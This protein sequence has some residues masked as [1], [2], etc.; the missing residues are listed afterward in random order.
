MGSTAA[1][2]VAIVAVLCAAAVVRVRGE[3]TVDEDT[4]GAS[5]IFGDSLVDAGNNNY[6]S[7]LSKADMNPNGIDFAA[8]GGN[9]TGRFT[10]GRTIADIIGNFSLCNTKHF[11]VLNILSLYDELGVAITLFFLRNNTSCHHSVT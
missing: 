6:L 9:P 7:T 5:F 4:P 10:N 3:D 1:A 2:V 8:S 11:Q